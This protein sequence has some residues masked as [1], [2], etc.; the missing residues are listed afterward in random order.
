[1]GMYTAS[2]GNGEGP[3]RKLLRLIL[4]LAVFLSGCI[5]YSE[6]LSLNR[7]GAGT[8]TLKMG[9]VDTE[10]MLDDEDVDELA[11]TLKED[12][13]DV[14]KLPGITVLDTASYVAD[15]YVWSLMTLEFESLEALRYALKNEE[16]PSVGD[17]S[18]T[19]EDGYL[20]FQ[21]TLPALDFQ[22][23]DHPETDLDED[24]LPPEMVEMLFEG[25]SWVY[26]AT[27]PGTIVAS[28]AQDEN[29]DLVTNTIRWSFLVT[30]L[31][32]AEGKMWAKIR[33]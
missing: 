10:A 3:M 22:S 13:E 25:V 31:L 26:A 32:Y 9:I 14:E 12:A 11:A 7:D 29:V 23:A 30:D 27:F 15:G 4:L 18:L 1:M 20:I 8:I 21:R 17:I 6:H 16:S 5:Q 19:E 24:D 28:N 2:P 33:L